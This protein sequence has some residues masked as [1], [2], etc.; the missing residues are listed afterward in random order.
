MDEPQVSKPQKCVKLGRICVAPT[1][2][3]EPESVK[4]NLTATTT[5]PVFI[6][7]TAV[8][9]VNIFIKTVVPV[10]QSHESVPAA[11]GVSHWPAPVTVFQS[12]RISYV[13][14]H[15]IKWPVSRCQLELPV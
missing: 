5:L 13:D 2:Q 15:K 3:A 9:P 1:S 8:A 12:R 10:A 14:I 4:T 6:L 7:G 11:G